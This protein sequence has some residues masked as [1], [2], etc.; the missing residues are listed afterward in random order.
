LPGIDQIVAK[1]TQVGD[2][3]IH[4]E[5]HKHINSIWNKEE[6]P[7]QWEKQSLTAPVYK[8]G[9]KTDCINY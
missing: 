2:E 1:L 6:L 9:D 8:K 5:I 7:G 4:S 3:T